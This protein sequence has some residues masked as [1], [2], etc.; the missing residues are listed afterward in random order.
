M[1]NNEKENNNF[2]ESQSKLNFEM[3]NCMTKSEFMEMMN[4][5]RFS[6]ILAADITLIGGVLYNTDTNEVERK[7]YNIIVR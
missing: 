5:L 4:N 7:T 1:L 6:H 2:L 3:S